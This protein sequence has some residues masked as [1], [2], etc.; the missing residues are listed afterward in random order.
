MDEIGADTS[1]IKKFLATKDFNEIP[2]DLRDILFYHLDLATNGDVVEVASSFFFG[3]EKLI[4]DMFTSMVEV[5][6]SAK[7]DCPELIYYFKRHIEVDGDEHGPMAMKC[8][9]TLA[10]TEEK[11]N[12]A[13]KTA[14]ESLGKRNALWSFIHDEISKTNRNQIDLPPLHI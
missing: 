6:E 9:D 7:M 8:L 12:L 11:L 13:H 2:K 4:P 14:I 3:R 5:L 10:D 1:M